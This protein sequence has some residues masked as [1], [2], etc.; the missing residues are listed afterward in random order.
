M[1]KQSSLI[2]FTGKMGGISFYKRKDGSHLARQ[3]GGVS[4]NRIMSDPRFQRTRENMAEFAGLIRAVSSFTQMLS[5]V[6]NFKDAT[7]RG[8]LSRV[9]RNVI[10]QS[11]GVRG[12]RSVTMSKNRELF[13]DL[14]LNTN[15]L[16]SSIIAKVKAT[17]TAERNKGTLTLA[18]LDV[19]KSIIPPLNATHFTLVQLVGVVSD[20][21]Y[22]PITKVYKALDAVHNA[23]SEISATDYLPAR[24]SQPINV[25]LETTLDTTTPLTAD[26]SVVQCLGIL[27]YEQLGT[28]YYPLNQGNA[29]KIVGVF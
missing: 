15:L 16:S 20:M 3:A 9:L 5:A 7:L 1:S 21:V 26:V 23:L 25:T 22:D 18:N 28:A 19:N 2:T 17:H 12:K 11:E 10:K 6:K 8:R 29:M 4:K 24:N 27:F 13:Q 14:E